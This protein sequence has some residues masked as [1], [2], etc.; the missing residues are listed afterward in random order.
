MPYR[1]LPEEEILLLKLGHHQGVGLFDEEAGEWI[2]ARYA[3]VQVHR[4][5]EVEAVL[6]AG[7][8]VHLT[9]GRGGVDDAGALIH[10]D[11]ITGYH[12]VGQWL[13]P[14][15]DYRPAVGL[16]HYCQ[17]HAELGGAEKRL[18]FQAGQPAAL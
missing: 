4:V 3:A 2:I 10:G 1:L 6:L 7:G 18:V 12:G 14:C 9:V 15:K 16:A 13:I 11:E 17:R 8:I 5:D